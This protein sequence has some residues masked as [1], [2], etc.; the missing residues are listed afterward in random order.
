MKIEPNT[1][2]LGGIEQKRQEGLGLVGK[3]R[4]PANSIGAGD[5]GAVDPFP[6]R[7]APIRTRRHQGDDLQIEPAGKAVA[8]RAHRLD[9]TQPVIRADICMRANGDGT[10]AEASE[11][12]PLGAVNDVTGRERAGVLVIGMYR[13]GKRALGITDDPSRPCF[14]KVLMHVDETWNDQ[15]PRQLGN[16][17]AN[18]N[19][20]R[21]ANARDISVWPNGDIARL[22]LH[23]AVE[24]NV[25]AVEQ[26]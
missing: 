3:R 13:T 25:A 24:K 26:K 14:I 8:Q 16:R 17:S 7:S 1:P 23:A 11:D 12:R 6:P 22:R 18:F 2:M 10:A 4:R 5:K 20:K 9:P 19:L 21:R 15:P